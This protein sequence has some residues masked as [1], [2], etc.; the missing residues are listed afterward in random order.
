MFL[1]KPV[2]FFDRRGQYRKYC[3]RVQC[4][5]PTVELSWWQTK[6]NVPICNW[7]HLYCQVQENLKLKN[8]G[9]R[10][11]APFEKEQWQSAT[12][13]TADLESCSKAYNCM[14]TSP[15]VFDD[16]NLVTRRPHPKEQG[17]ERLSRQEAGRIPGP[18]WPQVYNFLKISG[19]PSLRTQNWRKQGELGPT[20]GRVPESEAESAWKAE[21]DISPVAY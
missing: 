1:N 8:P 18:Y 15:R 5:L 14:G 20:S 21:S 11:W 19:E 10:K 16:G 3:V 9:R 4:W 6:T 17:E 13:N 12:W 7:K 2:S